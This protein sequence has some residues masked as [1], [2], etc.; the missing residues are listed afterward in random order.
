MILM[1]FLTPKR[2]ISWCIKDE[3]G[4]ILTSMEEILERWAKFYIELYDDLNI[5]EPLPTNDKLPITPIK[6]SEIISTINRLSSGKSPGIDNIHSEFVKA[7]GD[8]MVRIL[9]TLFNRILETGQI[10][11]TFRKALIVVLYK[12]DNISECKNY[13]P[14]SLL[15]HVYK[16]FM[17]I[18]GNRITD[19]LYSCLPDSQAAYQPDRGTIE[20]IFALNQVIEKSIEFNK[21]LIV[22]FIDFTKEFDRIKLDKHWSISNKTPLN[23]NEINLLKLLYYA[24]QASIKTDLGNSRFVNIKKV[25]KQGEMVSAI[26]FCVALAALMLKTEESCNS[27]FSIGSHIIYNLSY[28]DD[29]SLTTE[30]PIK[31]Q[32]FVNQLTINAKEIG[33]KTN[34][35][36]TESVRT[37]KLQHPL[38]LHLR[39]TNKAGHRICLFRASVD[40]LWKSRSYPER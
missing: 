36:K 20:Q 4:K 17:T 8:D 19:D 12:K 11:S 10:P 13:R 24:S 31:L 15:S 30:C 32:S 1:K 29:I 7:G 27:G 35:T 5:C 22:I 9:Y 14:I 6:K 26:L 37:D 3:D 21:P 34:L 39:Q 23:K 2:N 40:F 18:I 33:L 25:V 28:A 16:F 38:N